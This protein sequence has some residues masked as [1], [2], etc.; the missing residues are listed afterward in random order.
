[1][2]TRDLRAWSPMW[3]EYSGLPEHLNAK[4][5]GGAGWIFF[6]KI[7]ELDCDRNSAPGTVEISLSE[8]QKRCG[9]APNQARRAAAALRKMNLMACFLPDN[10]DEA[11]LFRLVTPLQTPRP[12]ELIRKEDPHL[13]EHAGD[14]LRYYDDCLHNQKD[15]LPTNDPALKETVDLYFDAISLKMNVF[16]LDELRMLP[17]RFEMQEVRSV[18][19][20]ARKNEI[21]SL[22]WIMQELVRRRK[23]S[24]DAGAEAEISLFPG[25]EDDNAIKF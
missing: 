19:R 15:D 1:M 11:A 14:F 5:K 7:V 22:H 24:G 9:V 13:F 12:P 4:I 8:L 25:N 20:Q 16:I 17:Q 3:L 2:T 6:K 18:F 21:R 23:K 10:D